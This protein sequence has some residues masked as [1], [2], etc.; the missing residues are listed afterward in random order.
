MVI[1]LTAIIF[2]VFLIII[3]ANEIQKS[4]C[5]HD[6]GISETRSCNAICRLCGKDLGFIGTEENK[7][8]RYKQ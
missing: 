6:G 5:K 8:R 3:F 2:G 4:F 1:I 7:K